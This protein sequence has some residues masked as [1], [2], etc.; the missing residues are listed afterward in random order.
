MLYRLLSI[1]ILLILLA[2]CKDPTYGLLINVK[3]FQ[4]ISINEYSITLQER[5]SAQRQIVYRSGIVRLTSRDISKQGIGIAINVSH[6]GSYL[7][8][9]RASAN[10]LSPEGEVPKPR[11]P[12]W[13]FASIISVGDVVEVTAPLLK[14]DPSLDLDNDHFPNSTMF[15]A[16]GTDVR[17]IYGSQ[18]A[19]LD[20]VDD[21]QKIAGLGLPTGIFAEDINPLAR[22]RCG[23]PIDLACGEV[24][25]ACQD[26]DKDGEDESTDCDDNDPQRFLA[27][28]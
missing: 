24:A 11:T 2:G 14:V 6:P 15:L 22:Q 3:A 12:E 27:L 16:S 9:I 17:S 4:E 10:E 7:V 28:G 21:D 1:I 5:S 19:V 23:L 25:P 26:K 20:C 8:H 13:F 18:I